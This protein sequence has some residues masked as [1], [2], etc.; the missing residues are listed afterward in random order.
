MIES[1]LL[2]GIA[3]GIAFHTA[4]LQAS[5]RT[6]I[7]DAYARGILTALCC[8]TTLSAGINMPSN[9]VIIASHSIGDRFITCSLY[10]QVIGRAG[11]G[12]KES[13][14]E[15]DSFIF[16][17]PDKVEKFEALLDSH[18]EPIE[19]SLR[20]RSSYYRKVRDFKP[21]MVTSE[22]FTGITRIVLGALDMGRSVLTFQEIIDMYRLTLLYQCGEKVSKG[23]KGKT[24]RTI[25]PLLV[26]LQVGIV[27]LIM[28]IFICLM[29]IIF[30]TFLQCVWQQLLAEGYIELLQP[31]PMHGHD[32]IDI[33]IT[34]EIIGSPKDTPAIYS[35]NPSEAN[36]AETDREELQGRLPQS[37]IV[38]Q[39]EKDEFLSSLRCDAPT[40]KIRNYGLRLTTFAAATAAGGWMNIIC[41]WRSCLCK[42][43]DLAFQTR[44]KLS[45]LQ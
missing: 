39:I 13:T 27:M 30:I 20:E 24:L 25:M 34:E 19:S 44:C 33:K 1:T 21:G 32:G 41:D 43:I 10:L 23:E 42:T 18:V 40:L 28:T 29:I 37:Q 9:R 6:A 31:V 45:R 26:E 35:H 8:T 12:T 11:R 22:R 14:S 2:A 36:S 7:E 5:E 38:P 15:P 16:L 17:S 3:V 4:A